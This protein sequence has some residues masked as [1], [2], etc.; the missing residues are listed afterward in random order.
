MKIA[1]FFHMKEVRWNLADEDV[2]RIEARFPGVRIVAIEDPADMLREIVDADAFVGFTIPRDVFVAAQRLRWV[3]SISAGVEDNLFAEM[4]ASDVV[5]TGGTGLHAVSIPEHVLGQM[6]VLARNFHEAQRLQAAQQWNRFQV[7]VFAAG[8]VELHG[9]N[10][11]I[12]GAGAIGQNLARRAAALG[13]HVRVLRRHATRGLRDVE[14]VVP[15][16]RLA[17][18]LSWADFVVLALPLTAETRHIVGEPQFAAM[19]SAAHLIN[20]GRG[21]LIDDDALVSALQRGAI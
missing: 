15:P 17:E 14:A 5:L 13:M 19:K 21:E 9:S 20:I 7:I 8:I 11:A 4:K 6:L 3:Q 2:R 16:E 18:L 1:A 10:L 12:L